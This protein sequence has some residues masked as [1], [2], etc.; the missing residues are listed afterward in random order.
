MIAERFIQQY[1]RTKKV[2]FCDAGTLA[3]PPS[4]A[5]AV[6]HVRVLH[7]KL[8]EPG[9]AQLLRN[10]ADTDRSAHLQ[11]CTRRCLS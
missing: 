6:F 1:E 5:D 4:C 2:E 10:E 3:L 8:R 9:L 11:N 7:G